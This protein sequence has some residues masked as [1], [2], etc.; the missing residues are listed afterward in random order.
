LRALYQTDPDRFEV[1]AVGSRDR[2]LMGYPISDFKTMQEVVA[3]LAEQGLDV[4][5]VVAR[6][7]GRRLVRD[8]VDGI[9]TETDELELRRLKHA[10][11]VFLGVQ[12]DL[13]RRGV[14]PRAV[15]Y[16]RYRSFFGGAS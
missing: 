8:T 9:L 13:A 1:L 16:E 10:E 6:E 12:E 14:I 11:M 5:D 2:W 7:N 15:A 3:F 4:T